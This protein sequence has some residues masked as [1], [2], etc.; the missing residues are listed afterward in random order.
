[1]Q[2]QNE[3]RKS[4]DI[5]LHNDFRLGLLATI[6]NIV[7]LAILLLMMARALRERGRNAAMLRRTTSEL[8]L[9]MEKTSLHNQQMTMVAEMLQALGSLTTLD[10]TSKVISTYCAKLLPGTSGALFLYRNSRDML[11]RQATWGTRKIDADLFEP[12]ACWALQR[13]SFHLAKGPSD[14][15]CAHYLEEPDSDVVRLCAPL[16]SQGQVIGVLYV[17]DLDKDP[18]TLEAQQQTIERFAEQI[19]LALVNVQLRDT[20]HRQS[21][22]DAL[23]G[24][25]NR[26]YLDETLKRELYRAQR[27]KLPLA[28]I[29]LDID[30]FKHVND[31]YGHDA[32]DAVLRLIAQLLRNNVRESD[33]A[34]RFGGEEL[35]IVLTECELASALERAETVREAIAAMKIDYDDHTITVTASFGVS[36][37]PDNGTEAQGL[38]QAADQALYE[39]KRSG[40]NRVVAAKTGQQ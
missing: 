33:L 36:I 22:T 32:G 34:C 39:A 29:V 23:T 21:V 14:L 30:H 5:K 16:I 4:L 1:M 3:L 38:I 15:R 25:F 35:V 2:D 19:A 27:K 9:S 37:H 17:E 28:V 8:S 12:K 18:V 31:T 6:V 11:E 7:V 10:E 24:L 26:R 20:L 13:G 40:R